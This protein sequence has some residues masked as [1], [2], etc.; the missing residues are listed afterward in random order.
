[1]SETKAATKRY[2]PTVDK[3][4][5]DQLGSDEFKFDLYRTMH[6]FGF[7]QNFGPKVTKH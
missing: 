1:M 6:V 4:L 7:S 2:A 5:D 3:L